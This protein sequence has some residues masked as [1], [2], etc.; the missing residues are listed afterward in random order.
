MKLK[1]LKVCEVNQYIKR[2][3]VSDPILY[4]INVEG[5]ISNFKHH[6]NGHMY[7]TLKDESSKIRCVMFNGDNRNIDFSP[8]EGMKVIITGYISVYERDGSY[9]LYA[10]KIKQKG[11]GDLYAAFEKLKKRLEAEGMFDNV[12]KKKLPYLPKKIGVVTSSTGAAIKDIITVIQRRFSSVNIVI[13]PV[14]VQGEK[15]PMEIVE[16]LRY[17]NTRDDIDLI[18]TGRGGGSIEELWAFNDEEVARTIFKLKIPIISAVGHETDFTIADF[19]ADLRAPTPSAAGELATPI[20]HEL[21]SRLEDNLIRLEFVMKNSLKDKENS[22]KMLRNNLKTYSPENKLKASKER[23]DVLYKDIRRVMKSVQDNSNN[24]LE[25]LIGRLD[26]LSP[27][28][29]LNRGYSIPLDQES[30]VIKSVKRVKKDDIV[31]ILLKDGK[32]T[33]KIISINESHE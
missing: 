12:F 18:I 7:F 16:A 8:K 31:D 10:K 19:V 9:Q 14:H 27:L 30:K 17:F 4:N 6:Y 1:A 5:E 28:S 23:L 2:I 3:L 33:G 21:K 15:A 11:V 32:I 25:N 20:L 22:L 26:A 29:T 13:Y 24:K